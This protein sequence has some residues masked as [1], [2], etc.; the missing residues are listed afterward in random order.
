NFQHGGQSLHDGEP[1]PQAPRAVPFRVADL[2]E[3]LKDQLVLVGGDAA[4]GVPHLDAQPSAATA[5]NNDA[6]IVGIADRVGYEIAQEALEQDRVAVDR[7]RARDEA[8][9]DVLALQLGRRLAA[10]P[11]HKRLN[12]K[13]AQVDLNDARVEP[14]NVEKRREQA[15]EGAD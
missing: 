6:S 7:H 2:V 4:T 12:A 8:Q 15:V 5:S 3:F 10:D 1:Q 13:R 14:R 11:F 9:L